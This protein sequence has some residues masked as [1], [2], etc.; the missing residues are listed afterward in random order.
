[1]VYYMGYNRL[2]K[3]RNFLAVVGTDKVGKIRKLKGRLR[4]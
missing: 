3:R 2:V 1:M 4:V